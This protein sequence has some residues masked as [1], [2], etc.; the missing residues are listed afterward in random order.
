MKEKIEKLISKIDLMI[1]GLVLEKPMHGYEINQIISAEE[2]QSWLE[3]SRTS[4]YYALTRLKKQG[5]I[6]EVVEKQYNKPD[7]SI[8]RITE[9]GRELFFD[10]L[11]LSLAEQE[12]V[13][14]DYNIGLF[15]MNKLTKEKAIGVLEERKRFLKK[16]RSSLASQL[17]LVKGNSDHPSTLKA[18]LDHTLAFAEHEAFWLDSFLE[19]LREDGST[20]ESSSGSVF[21]LSGNLREAQ[22]PDIIRMIA[23]G[24]RTGTLA[25]KNSANTV[26]ISFNKGKV[27]YVASPELLDSG[28]GDNS[29][30]DGAV[31]P[32]I[33]KTFNWPDGDFTFTPDMVIDNGGVELKLETCALVLS[34]CRLVDD[35]NRIKKVVS[36][37]SVIYERSLD[38]KKFK[39]EASLSNEEKA[40]LDQINGIR[41]VE[42][43]AEVT[44]LSIFEVSRILYTFVICGQIHTASRDR[45]ELFDLLKLFTNALFERL[46]AI[47]AERIAEQ[48]AESLNDLSAKRNMPFSLDDFKLVDSQ[49]VPQ[50]LKKFAEL[51]EEFYAEQVKAVS[52]QLGSRFTQHVIESIVGQLTPE[53]HD[54]YARYGLNRFNKF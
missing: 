12:K 10:S 32:E 41:S 7:R 22:L 11:S 54:V 48:I 1:L 26:M 39:S 53:M 44:S 42:R 2:M 17:K 49:Q 19:N 16:W 40:V 46:N 14:L 28:N 25:V 9:A 8:F 29:A 52:S 38:Q 23:S 24:G 6:T 47:K 37:S 35:W 4:V 3:I 15:F 30:G 13:F 27:V 34:G 21:S 36:S 33:L 50:D 20:S 51:V 18:V 5:L 45:G 43:L 31:P